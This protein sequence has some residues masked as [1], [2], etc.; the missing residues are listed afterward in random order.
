M[1]P[2]RR[3]PVDLI[4]S[5]LIVVALVIAGAAVWYFSSARR[6]T[7]VPATVSPVAPP[8][9]VDV[10]ARLIHRWTAESE[11][12]RSP[13]V[14]D[15][16]V[17]TGHDGAVRARDPRTGRAIWGYE[18]PLPICGL[19]AA[20][21]PTTP[22]ALAAY[23]NSRGCSEITALDAHRGVR[24]GTRSSDA[25]N[26]VV[27]QSDGG[28]VLS[29]GRTRA[30]TWGSNLV[31]GIEYG[32]IDARVKPDMGRHDGHDCRL[33]SGMTAG[34]RVAL[35]EHCA[36]DPGFRLTVI[37]A[38]LDKDEKIPLYGSAVITSGTAFAA[39]VVVGMSESGIAV[40]DGGANSPEPTAP[41]IRTFTSDGVET[42]RHPVPG[43]PALPAGAVSVNSDGLVS[44]WTGHD[45]VVLDAAALRPRFTVPATSGPG[46][47]VG[48]RMLVPDP[49]GYTV[50]DAATGRRVGALPVVRDLGQTPSVP[51]VPA[52]IGDAVVEQRGNLI[53][54]YG[55]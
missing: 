8:Y 49:A 20:W 34:D 43:G 10:P 2:L 9:P 32:R 23:A 45:T 27:L 26:P 42:G 6:T 11:A 44:V 16:A 7:L 35:V 3:R 21:S 12:T 25:D 28:Y 13:Q 50:V 46:V 15:T 17:L 31:R 51:I 52:V 19:L 4:V 22:T 39:P 33:T 54:A 53:V 37:G 38:L 36:G 55:P 1:G 24:R 29:L 41:A 18:R 14:T 30:E 5:A 48:G 40:Y 47:A